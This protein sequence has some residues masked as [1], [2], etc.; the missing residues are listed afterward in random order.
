MVTAAMRHGGLKSVDVTVDGTDV[1]LSPVSAE[2]ADIVRGNDL[3]DLGSASGR[4]AL[5]AQGATVTARDG[6]VLIALPS[7]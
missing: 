2:T 1:E 3:R 6:A 4:I 7:A 5:E